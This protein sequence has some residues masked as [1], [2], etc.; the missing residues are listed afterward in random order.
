MV[1]RE[2][3]YVGRGSITLRGTCYQPKCF[4]ESKEEIC[5]KKH[6]YLPTMLDLMSAGTNF[7]S[8]FTSS[9]TNGHSII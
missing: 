2:E 9:M 1:A 6:H 5:N 3:I 4:A 8:I 7:F